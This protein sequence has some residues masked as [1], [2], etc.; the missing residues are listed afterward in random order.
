MTTTNIPQYW[1]VL[2][3]VPILPVVIVA[4]GVCFWWLFK[5]IK[6]LDNRDD[7]IETKVTSQ[8]KPILDAVKKDFESLKKEHDI[9][10]GDYTTLKNDYQILKENYRVL[11]LESEAGR[12]SLT[13]SRAEDLTKMSKAIHHLAAAVRLTDQVPAKDLRASILAELRQ[14]EEVLR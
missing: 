2:Q 4:I 10:K 11:K 8:L 1:D 5:V 12:D 13:L 6:W 14:A 3:S 7:E 9:L